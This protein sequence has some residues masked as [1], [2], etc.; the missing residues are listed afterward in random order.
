MAT[1]TVNVNSGS[2][3][4]S[5][6]PV[7]VGDTVIFVAGGPG[8]P[9]SVTISGSTLFGITT[10]AVP[11]APHNPKVQAGATGSFEVFAGASSGGN[12]VRA[13]AIGTILVTG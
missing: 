13:G 5:S 3:V 7:K 10:V 4:P 8:A 1:H 11:S 2:M 9:S 12:H 6:L